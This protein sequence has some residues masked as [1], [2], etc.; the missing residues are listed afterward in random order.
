MNAIYGRPA[1]TIP[2][3]AHHPHPNLPAPVKFC[4]PT[5]LVSGK[6]DTESISLRE[7]YAL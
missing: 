3:H 7:A 4:Q 5:F 6:I 2:D 1:V